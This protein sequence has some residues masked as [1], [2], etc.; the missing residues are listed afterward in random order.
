[1]AIFEERLTFEGKKALARMLAGEIKIKFTRM[2]VGDGELEEGTEADGL[3]GLVHIKASKQME[4][5]TVSKENVV[6]VAAVFRNI[7]I[8]DAF[9]Y[10]EKG[11]FA[12]VDEKEILFLYAN[13][14]EKA[15][16]IEPSRS[17]L[18]E[19][20]IRSILIFAENDNLNIEVASGIYLSA[21]NIQES[22]INGNFKVNEREI[23]VYR[24][25][26]EGLEFSES[27]SLENIENGE[28]IPSA[29]GKIKRAIR[30]LINHIRD[31]NN[32]HKVSF[33]NISGALPINK[34]GTGATTIAGAQANLGLRVA[35]ND[36][37]SV[38][39]YVADARIVKVHGDEI[40]AIR[41]NFT[42]L[43]TDFNALYALVMNTYIRIFEGTVYF[44]AN[45][46]GY[47]NLASNL[48]E[49]R[50]VLFVQN[51]QLG[52]F[53]ILITGFQLVTSRRVL[54]GADMKT[55]SADHCPISMGYLSINI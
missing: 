29:F 4:Y 2:A 54:I 31:F 43:N 55:A 20:L 11:V 30:E 25:E 3:T 45:G 51:K 50:A 5:V 40:D 41:N 22:E 39:G 36:Q 6:T 49:A 13:N 33:E 52:G 48:P 10:R 19:K 16:W 27:E 34:G 32:P 12:E 7:D 14:G 47:V 23:K 35:N 8:A 28:K 42:D 26:E 21:D 53:D 24:L 15:E 44:D 9:F 17:V 46:R 1:M 18:I 38:E 37:T